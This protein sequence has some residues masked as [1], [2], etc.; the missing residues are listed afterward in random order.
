MG[1]RGNWSC[2]VLL[3]WQGIHRAPRLFPGIDHG[4]QWL[5]MAMLVATYALDTSYYRHVVLPFCRER[6]PCRSPL[7]LSA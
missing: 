7:V 2:H 6:L 4:S 3:L 5:E 1:P